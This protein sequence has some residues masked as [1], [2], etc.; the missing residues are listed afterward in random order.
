MCANVM[1]PVFELAQISGNTLNQVAMENVLSHGCLPIP[2]NPSRH[3]LGQ[4]L[5]RVVRICIDNQVFIEGSLARQ[6]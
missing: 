6:N 5:N 1:E 3:P 2:R 4:T